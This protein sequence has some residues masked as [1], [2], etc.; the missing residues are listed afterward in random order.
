M[1]NGVDVAP[2][3][4]GDAQLGGAVGDCHQQLMLH[5]DGSCFGFF[6]QEL[7]WREAEV[8]CRKLGAGIHLASIHSERENYAVA[9]LISRSQHYNV[10]DV[11]VGLHMTMNFRWEWTDGSKVQYQAWDEHEGLKKHLCVALEATTGG[12]MG[13]Q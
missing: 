1:G 13:Q 6:P 12:H 5:E 10:D 11:W 2:W 7:P 9:D 8:F 3:L 4:G